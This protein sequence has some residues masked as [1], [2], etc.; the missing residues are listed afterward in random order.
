VAVEIA[1]RHDAVDVVDSP[2]DELDCVGEQRN[3]TG[4]ERT[5]GERRP[6]VREARPDHGHACAALREAGSA[7]IS[8]NTV[9][10]NDH[11]IHPDTHQRVQS[12]VASAKPRIGRWKA[13]MCGTGSCRCSARSLERSFGVQSDLRGSFVAEAATTRPG[14]AA[15]SRRELFAVAAALAATVLTGVAAVAG[16]SR[17]VPAAPAVP[18]VGQTI[19]PAAPNVPQRV[20]PG[21]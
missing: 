15:P 12:P 9:A 6:V 7:R 4:Q 8:S 21:D 16:L 18:T 10:D 14:T 3:S 13:R 20:E 5:L 17:R 19:T 11:V 1:G 2:F